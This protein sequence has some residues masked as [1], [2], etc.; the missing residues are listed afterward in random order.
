[1]IE[2]LKLSDIRVNGDTQLR[3]ETN[4]DIVASYAM[5]MLAGDMFPPVVVYH[6]GEDYWLSDGFH[7]FYASQQIGKEDITADVRRGTRRDALLHGA[8][9]NRKHG[10][11]LT[12]KDK[13]R[14]VMLFLHD[15][16]WSRWSDR[17]IARRCGVS[18]NFVSSLRTS[19]SLDDS[20]ARTYITKHGSVATMQTARIGTNL[21]EGLPHTLI[22]DL[23]DVKAGPEDIAEIAKWAREYKADVKRCAGWALLIGSWMLTC[24]EGN[25]PHIGDP[26]YTQE[27]LED[28][29]WQM[30]CIPPGHLET[31]LTIGSLERDLHAQVEAEGKDFFDVT[32]DDM[33]QRCTPQLI[34]LL[35]N[36]HTSIMFL[37]RYTLWHYL[38][39]WMGY[40]APEEQ[41]EIA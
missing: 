36:F 26:P 11:Q 12:N 30:W 29:V 25:S 33:L 2:T 14:I 23:E 20:E 8:E 32:V 5:D 38:H 15:H 1:M 13:R 28:E 6:D 3:V 24:K 35:A 4:R 34:E 10:L 27:Q 41:K 39:T 22:K 21:Y 37:L 31:C 18:H 40:K 9:A 17:E 16:E 7:R 19:L